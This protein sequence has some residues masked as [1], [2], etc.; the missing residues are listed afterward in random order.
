M[1]YYK[2]YNYIIYSNIEISI[3][4]SLPIQRKLNNT[5][6]IFGLLWQ[7]KLVKEIDDLK[8]TFKNNSI[9]IDNSLCV[10]DI[11]LN[12]KIIKA[13]SDTQEEMISTLFNLPFSYISL[14]YNNLILHGSSIEYL[15][16]AYIFCAQKGTGKTTLVA[17]LI[18]K[19]AFY[20]DD[21]LLV[22]KYLSSYGSYKYLKLIDPK[23]FNIENSDLQ[24]NIQGKYYVNPNLLF[25]HY[26]N[27]KEKLQLKTIFILKKHDI[28]KIT[29]KILKGKMQ[30]EILLL[31]SIVGIDYLE[32]TAIEKIKSS[33]TFNNIINSVN[34]VELIVP[35]NLILLEQN[36]YEII[37]FITKEN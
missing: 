7:H 9:K 35:N 15:D 6:L 23:L 3:L 25:S 10:Y 18:E 1:Y 2:I 31:S 26:K 8:I 33:K 19:F 36:I 34:I 14:Y 22:D 11:Q 27:N 13:F 12:K 17:K 37:D 29:F 5:T 16:N 24:Q 21:T 32:Y 20:Y 30:K 28:D 4:E